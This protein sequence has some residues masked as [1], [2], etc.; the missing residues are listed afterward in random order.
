MAK[1]DGN[2]YGNNQDNKHGNKRNNKMDKRLSDQLKYS[3]R[4]YQKQFEL[5][6][7]THTLVGSELFRKATEVEGLP[8]VVVEF[9]AYKEWLDVIVNTLKGCG[10]DVGNV[11]TTDD[12][13]MIVRY[14]V[15]SPLFLHVQYTCEDYGNTLSALADFLLYSSLEGNTD[16]YKMTNED[17]PILSDTQYARR[18]GKRGVRSFYEV[19]SIWLE[20]VGADMITTNKTPTNKRSRQE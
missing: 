18:T 11:L 13:L 2:K 1:E 12:R 14:L 4:Y 19:S 8:G 17:Y 20:N 15:N 10:K 3:S 9:G 7:T 5:L 6:L 16:T